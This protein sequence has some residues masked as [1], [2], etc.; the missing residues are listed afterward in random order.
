MAKTDI[1]KM[2]EEALNQL[3][4]T[5]LT[6]SELVQYGDRAKWTKDD[7]ERAL[8]LRN[9]VQQI[10]QTKSHHEDFI[11][12]LEEKNPWMHDQPSGRET[13]E[14]WKGIFHWFGR[15]LGSCRR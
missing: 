10:D 4:L 13:S 12:D 11:A 7:L 14:A 3:D 6:A 9:M 2:S 5:M 1:L 15:L 8:S